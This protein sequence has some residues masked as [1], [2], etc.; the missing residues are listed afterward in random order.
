VTHYRLECALGAT[1]YAHL[2]EPLTPGLAM[3]SAIGEEM[4]FDRLLIRPTDFIDVLVAML[5]DK[6][7][8]IRRLEHDLNR[9]KVET[10]RYH[11]LFARRGEEMKGY[12][13]ECKAAA[14]RIMGPMPEVP[15][16]GTYRY[17]EPTEQELDMKDRM[18]KHKDSESAIEANPERM[19]KQTAK[20][21]KMANMQKGQ[22]HPEVK[23][24]P[25]KR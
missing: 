20:T 3:H 10:N 17:E 14:E 5:R 7:T 19:A 1:E 9:A 2:L 25:K 22:K 15:D 16:I 4:E 6:V 11:D 21:P 23:I 8:E 18:M 24:A 13:A 12:A